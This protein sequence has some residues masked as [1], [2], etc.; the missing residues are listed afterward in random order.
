[1][2]KKNIAE[3]EQ[4]RQS[5][6]TLQG[7]VYTLQRTEKT[8]RASNEAYRKD[9]NRFAEKYKDEVAINEVLRKGY[10]SFESRY[11]NAEYYCNVYQTMMS[12][13][14]MLLRVACEQTGN[15]NV[16]EAIKII[17]TRPESSP[18]EKVE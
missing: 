8:L 13:I 18:E 17:L 14:L 10:V 7:T 16:T 15:E 1:M 6:K 11:K 9:A 2:K 5:V 3:M 4:L 12:K